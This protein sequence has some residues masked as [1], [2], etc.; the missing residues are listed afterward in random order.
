MLAPLIKKNGKIVC[1]SSICGS[2]VIDGAP[3]GYSIA[4]SAINNYVKSI[5]YELG[6]EYFY[7]FYCSRKFIF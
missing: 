4:K 5:S 7:Q 3:I 6:K 1:I 2:E